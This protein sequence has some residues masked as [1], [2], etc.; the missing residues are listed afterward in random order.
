MMTAKKLAVSEV[1]GPTVQGEGPSTGR[2]AVFLRLAGCNLACSWCDTPYTWDWTNY[3]K[4]KEVEVRPVASVFDEVNDRLRQLRGS[5]TALLVV[6]GGEPLLQAEALSALFN[7]LCRRGSNPMDVEVETNGTCYPINECDDHTQ[8]RPLTPMWT[9]AGCR[10]FNVSYNVSPKLSN[11]GEHKLGDGQAASGT[12][13]TYGGAQ[14]SVGLRKLKVESFPRMLR[15]SKYRLKF[16]VTRLA[17]V[18]EAEAIVGNFDADKRPEVWL[19]PEGTEGAQLDERLEWIVP[20]AIKR[21]WRVTDRLHVRAFEGK[22]G[23]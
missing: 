21:G 19:M 7:K 1:F 17:D 15:K 9:W 16:V 3:D 12:I 22:R 13:E 5:E 6:T 10:W 14:P 23:Y 20:A 18:E 2:P 4:S 11:S 8:E